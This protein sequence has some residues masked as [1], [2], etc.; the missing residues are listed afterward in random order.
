[1]NRP[2]RRLSTVLSR[3]LLAIFLVSLPGTREAWSQVVGQSG[4][5]AVSGITGSVGTTLG[6]LAPVPG[7]SAPLAPLNLSL[8]AP[9][10]GALAPIPALA[11][12]LAIMPAPVAPSIAPKAVPVS[13]KIALTAAAKGIPNI[14]APALS[15]GDLKAAAA[16]AFDGSE[17]K[18][19]EDHSVLAPAAAP[20][21][22]GLTSSS[23]WAPQTIETPLPADAMAVTIHRLSNGMTV[24]LSP[25]R[26]M[27][28]VTAR[29]AVRAG[30]RQ[31]PTDSTGMAH[32]LEHM[33]FKG[34]ERL[35]TVDYE[36]EKPHLEKIAALY[37]TLFTE[38]DADRRKA[39]YSEIDA[40]NQKAAAY[41]VPNELDRLFAGLGFKETNAHTSIEETVYE[42][43]FPSNRAEAWARIAAER[44]GRPVFRLFQSELE[45]VFEEHNREQD[46]PDSAMQ[47]A[48]QA[49]AFKGHAYARS[50]MGLPEHLK[51]PSLA[52]MY[53][54]YD[55]WY[56]PG[57]MAVL[58]SG[59]F[60]RAEM[61]ATLEKNLGTLRA[62]TPNT[63]AAPATAFEPLK[64]VERSEIVAPGEEKG[65]ISWRTPADGHADADALTV[66]ERLL[67]DPQ[68][69]LLNLRLAQA[70]KVKAAG[71]GIWQLTEAGAFQVEFEPKAGQ[72]LEQAE[73]LVMAELERVKAGDFT[74][75]NLRAAITNI[76]VQEKEKL[77][78]DDRRV[79]SMVTS[80][81]AGEEWSRS[82]SDL[83]RLRKITKADVVRVARAYL[84]KD[85]AVVY[86]RQGEA[87]HP[88]IEK[89]GFTPIS[90]DPTRRSPLGVELAALPAPELKA[91]RLKEGEDF[92]VR[93][94]GW[95]KLYWA[96]NPVS[97]LFSLA[98]ALPG[99]Y[100]A[101]PRML[102]A[103]DLLAASGA[104]DMSPAEFE[105]ALARLGTR[106]EF[107]CAEKEC[108]VSL[109]GL[110]KNLK[111]SLRL[112]ALRF[113]KPNI[114]RGTLQA[115]VKTEL[116]VRKD[117]KQDPEA[118]GAALR[119]Y[120]ERGA[121]SAILAGPSAKKLLA[122]RTSEM[123][124]L[125]A[126]TLAFERDVLYT[127]SVSPAT[128]ARLSTL[129]RRRF[130]PAPVRAP[131]LVAAPLETQVLFVHSKGMV[132]AHV[133]LFASDGPS[134]PA[135]PLDVAVARRFY[136]SVV[137][138]MSGVV[139][140]EVREARSLAYSADARYQESARRGDDAEL[141]GW[142]G[143]QADK[144]VSAAALMKEILHRDSFGAE[145]FAAAI[146]EVLT[147]YRANGIPFRSVPEM[148]LMWERLGLGAKDPRDAMLETA[149]AFRLADLEAMG[150]RLAG[151]TLT[152]YVVGDRAK[153]DMAG[154]KRLGKFKEVPLNSIFPR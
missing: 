2:V 116:G 3:A 50:T 67:A 88:A 73:A 99:G 130:R 105:Q 110:E 32:Y 141:F 135:S 125:L 18:G 123:R 85:R 117:E 40:E 22:P 92:V 34:T 142:V 128:V 43:T 140:Q 54:F 95:G 89:P 5:T 29:V 70:Q 36:K 52:K 126:R 42:E 12:A 118:I 61:L 122:L 87:K 33:L 108:V 103:A 86:R 137:G 69:G 13:A 78:S 100:R 8:S 39:L 91:Q 145:R 97:D 26:L 20:S 80:F 68:S 59:D 124:R 149:S 146:P 23:L 93:K 21:E 96:K 24:Y 51:N 115:L 14:A 148:L 16:K 31:D 151:R 132:Q 15:G 48:T 114:P 76:E 71:A 144:A 25:N 64:G 65:S 41:A 98:L 58:L 153:L 102:L 4:V 60:D 104:G 112:M 46:D 27:P 57:N 10:I 75:E 138:G 1:M 109:T 72:T 133:G 83:E 38:K 79:Q 63:P 134:D 127:G 55:A 120:A 53:A 113:S 62:R 17:G 30:S 131:A 81:I 101:D 37:E 9:A 94:H 49:A 7:L 6:A 139:F 44:Y 45:A 152:L 107:K 147:F 111:E 121:D 136:N 119:Q 82:V 90:I 106:M 35:G 77:E 150:R 84:G 129:G 19:T 11:A 74:E 154:L 28:Q 47:D 56:R 143:S 66:L